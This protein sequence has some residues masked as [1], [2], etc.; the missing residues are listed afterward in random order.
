M[1]V[2][3]RF[4]MGKKS[5]VMFKRFGEAKK[6]GNE[7]ITGIE[8]S[9]VPLNLKIAPDSTDK[10]IR[11]WRIEKEIEKEM[12]KLDEVIRSLKERVE[13]AR[14]KSTSSSPSTPSDMKFIPRRRTVIDDG[15]GNILYYLR[16]SNVHSF[17]GI[18]DLEE[19]IRSYGEVR[20]V[21]YVRDFS[22]IKCIFR[23]EENALACKNGLDT[24][25]YKYG[26][27]RTRL[28]SNR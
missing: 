14:S 25:S 16:I 26:C 24:V 4:Q 9:D 18:E 20:D 10:Y 17:D 6:K 1:N 12:V 13:L 8:L 2:M 21:E 23:R 19:K 28:N 7:D 15:G 22:S 27:L 3:K 5:T 11:R